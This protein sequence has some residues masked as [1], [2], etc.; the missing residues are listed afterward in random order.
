MGRLAT[1]IA[2]NMVD[3]IEAL[4]DQI[5]AI[6]REANDCDGG[7]NTNV[8]RDAWNARQTRR[9]EEDNERALLGSFDAE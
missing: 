8:I 4:Q 6:Y 1:A 5:D 3:R 9:Q 2:T 7:G